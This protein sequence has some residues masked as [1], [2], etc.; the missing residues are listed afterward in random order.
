M[1]TAAHIIGINR[2]SIANFVG[3]I[4]AGELDIPVL[5]NKSSRNTWGVNGVGVN[6]VS[7]AGCDTGTLGQ[8]SRS[9]YCKCQNTNGCTTYLGHEHI[10]LLHD[11]VWVI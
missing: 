11:H 3:L 5:N 9:E 6:H 7:N 1:L 4:N 2:V 10:V 8:Q